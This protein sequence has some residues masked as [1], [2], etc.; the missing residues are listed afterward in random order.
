MLDVPMPFMVI[1]FKCTSECCVLVEHLS[2][3]NCNGWVWASVFL[4]HCLGRFKDHEASAMSAIVRFG[5]LIAFNV[6]DISLF[7]WTKTRQMIGGRPK[8]DQRGRRRPATT[9]ATVAVTADAAVADQQRV[10][11]T[12]ARGRQGSKS[13]AA[14]SQKGR[15]RSNSSGS[16][17]SS[18]STQGKVLSVLAADQAAAGELCDVYHTV[19]SN[20]V[21][22]STHCMLFPALLLEQHL[23][24]FAEW[25]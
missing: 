20:M 25:Q 17:G 5:M 12:G 15:R 21:N 6:H 24:R 3:H 2:R 23:C 4:V 11:Q 10:V 19:A 1:W 7:V 9:S 16:R 14:G 18:N 22:H 8:F 13:R